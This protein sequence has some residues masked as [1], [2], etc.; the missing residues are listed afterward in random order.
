IGIVALAIGASGCS[1]QGGPPGG[2]GGFGGFSIPVTS[3]PLTRGTIEQ[4]F[5]VT[6]DIAPLQTAALSSVASGTVMAVNAQI[7]EH[8]SKGEQLVKIDDGPLRAQLQ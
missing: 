5:S 8:A 3:G 6:G 2:G 4:T 1:H 7:G